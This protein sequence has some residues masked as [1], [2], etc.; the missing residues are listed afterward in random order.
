[1]KAFNLPF[2]S[3]FSIHLIQLIHLLT[4]ASIGYCMPT[5]FISPAIIADK[6][7][8][9]VWFFHFY[10][11]IDK[12]NFQAIMLQLVLD[13]SFAYRFSPLMTTKW[14]EYHT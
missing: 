2:T 12:F 6:Q 9:A 8:L 13:S 10:S 5:G 3:L 4:T 14:T 11:Y 7:V 1:M